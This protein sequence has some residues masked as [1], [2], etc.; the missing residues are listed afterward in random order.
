MLLVEA[1]CPLNA[2]ILCY[3]IYMPIFIILFSNKYELKRQI[4][5]SIYSPLN[6]NHVNTKIIP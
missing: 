1:P 2:H 4:T 6:L 3:A 5:V